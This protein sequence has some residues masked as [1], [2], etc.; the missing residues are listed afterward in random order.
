MLRS[1]SQLTQVSAKE[2]ATAAAT[3]ERQAYWRRQEED[4]GE[5]AEGAAAFLE[6]REPRFPW[7]PGEG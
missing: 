6:R 1:R 2:Y 5:A 4:S 3:A 7:S